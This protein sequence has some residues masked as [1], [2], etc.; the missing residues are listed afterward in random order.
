MIQTLSPGLFGLQQQNPNAGLSQFTPQYDPAAMGVPDASVPTAPAAP[1]QSFVWG[2]AGDRLTDDDIAKRDQ[3]DQQQIANGMSFAPVQS[4]T[5]GAARVAQLLV[6]K[7]DERSL[8]KASA[9]NV[10]ATN[11]ALGLMAK[12]G[13]DE[14][15][16][17][18]LLADPTLS[19]GLHDVAKAKLASMYKAPPKPSELDQNL[20]AGGM[21]SSDPRWAKVHLQAAQNQ[22]DPIHAIP[23]DDPQTGSSGLMFKRA[24]EINGSGTPAI[25]LPADPAAAAQQYASMPAGTAFI[26]PQG[27]HRVKGSSPAP[28][29]A[30]SQG[31]GGFPLLPP[32][33]VG[34]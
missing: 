13:A 3:I 33:H 21:D 8:D 29:S 9:A 25:Q 5:Q 28:G 15:T 18:S 6:G 19:D 24:S 30:T 12:P 20:I 23:F 31:V 14:R 34:H 16:I 1:A 2:G 26:D 4:W 27:Q 7:L 10:T 17:A 22:V 32:G 11:D